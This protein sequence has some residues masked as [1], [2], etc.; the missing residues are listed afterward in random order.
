M[1]VPSQLLQQSAQRLERCPVAPDVRQPRRKRSCWRA[2]LVMSVVAALL[3]A[4][5]AVLVLCLPVGGP[6]LQREAS[7]LIRQATGLEAQAGRARLDFSR[8]TL[9]IDG[10]EVWVRGD[11]ANTRIAVG[12][13]TLL[14]DPLGA[15]QLHPNSIRELRIRAGET[16]RF[17]DTPTGP[18]LG[19][20]LRALL[21]R[22]REHAESAGRDA[23]TTTLRDSGAPPP[24]P[25]FAITLQQLEVRVRRRGYANPEQNVG[26]DSLR[27][28]SLKYT[29]NPPR[30]IMRGELAAGGRRSPIVLWGARR[31][32]HHFR[33][34]GKAGS[35]ESRALVQGFGW[36]REAQAEIEAAYEPRSGGLRFSGYLGLTPWQITEPTLPGVLELGPSELT[37]SGKMHRGGIL[38]ESLVFRLVSP[39]GTVGGE[40]VRHRSGPGRAEWRATASLDSLSSNVIHFLWEPP[41]V[42]I[43]PLEISSGPAMMTLRV[44]ERDGRVPRESIRWRIDAAGATLRVDRDGLRHVQAHITGAAEGTID[45]IHTVGPVVARLPTGR[46]VEIEFHSEGRRWFYR[47]MEYTVRARAEVDEHDILFLLPETW[48]AAARP[49]SPR[50]RGSVEAR[51]FKQRGNPALY[52]V[53]ASAKEGSLTPP[54]FWLTEPV[55]VAGGTVRLQRHRVDA[56]GV[57]GR[58]GDLPLRANAS[59]SNGQL[60]AGLEVEGRLEQAREIF[61][62]VLQPM[63]LEGD[64]AAEVQVVMPPEEWMPGSAVDSMERVIAAGADGRAR[65]TAS[66]HVRNGTVAHLTMPTVLRELSGAVAYADDR[67]AFAD[68]TCEPTPG[69]WGKL[70]GYL[71]FPRGDLP[72]LKL[73][74]SLDHLAGDIWSGHWFDLDE[75]LI[76]KDSEIHSV[77]LSANQLPPNQRQFELGLV[78]D[79]QTFAWN[80]LR[81]GPIRG[82]LSFV[83]PEEGLDTLEIPRIDA[84]LY[85]GR[86]IA[87]FKMSLPPKDGPA[88]VNYSVW[89]EGRD[90]SISPLLRDW[91]GNDNNLTGR[92]FVRAQERGAIEDDQVRRGFATL[93]LMQTNILEIPVFDPLMRALGLGKELGGQNGQAEGEISFAQGR[94]WTNEFLIKHPV[95]A[96]LLNGSVG[97]SGD[98]DLSVAARLTAARAGRIPVL[99]ILG[100]AVEDVGNRILSLRIGG[101]AKSPSIETSHVRNVARALAGIMGSEQGE[102]VEARSA[103]LENDP[104]VRALDEETF[105]WS[106]FE[107]WPTNSAIP[108]EL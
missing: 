19:E 5:V 102:E 40:A 26:S 73:R 36:G 93:R 61:L 81:G 2:L 1:D 106:D 56:W 22:L 18:E 103:D 43:S 45:S 104:F 80:N 7:K 39:S 47:Q 87:G 105:T 11:P 97:G 94:Y 74:A 66:G 79:A 9:T 6:L 41:K 70:S 38:P 31:G 13:V 30:L 42:G 17:Y 85:D 78:V 33:L 90:I 72:K 20:R 64:A 75:A 62:P 15:L 54:L 96:L 49:W 23:A 92:L 29:P 67:L 89:L 10:I 51:V 83:A 44:Q 63:M 14:F 25:D 60:H 100:S 3:P 35:F 21:D 108:P 76:A 28:A 48:Q 65:V 50:M 58:I 84:N 98:L 52:S 77:P 68:V 95:V 107:Q 4:S 88:P 32:R 101:N 59:I 12:G 57:T 8:G 55:K 34:S 69:T 99:N 86:A 53:E 27:V 71:D 37:F 16:I 24:F 46:P 82:N 91:N